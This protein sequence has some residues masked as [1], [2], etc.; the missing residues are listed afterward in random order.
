[1]AGIYT[2]DIDETL[3]FVFPFLTGSEASADTIVSYDVEIVGDVVEANS[4]NDDKTVVVFISG[5]TLGSTNLI[6]VRITSTEGRVQEGVI[7]LQVISKQAQVPDDVWK[8]R[9]NIGDLGGLD[10][11]DDVI[12]FVLGQYE[13]LDEQTIIRKATVDVLRHLVGKFASTATRRREREGG[14]EVENYGNEKW[15]TYKDL[16]DLWTKDASFNPHVGA[17]MKINTSAPRYSVS[18]FDDLSEPLSV[19][20]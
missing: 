17:G 19:R 18:Q 14:V 20:R 4:V 12:Q 8:V 7:A 15:K 13:D 5:G 3:D 16:Y 9:F 1:M 10:V 11:S 6:T 2:K